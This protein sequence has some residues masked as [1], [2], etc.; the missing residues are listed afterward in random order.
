MQSPRLRICDNCG[1]K[2][3]ALATTSMN[4]AAVSMPSIPSQAYDDMAL[5]KEFE[6]AFLAKPSS[7]G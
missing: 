4:R 7:R 2:D 6:L 5:S 3:A 1:T